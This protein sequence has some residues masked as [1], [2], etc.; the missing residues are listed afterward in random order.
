[1]ISN[2]PAAEQGDDYPGKHQTDQFDQDCRHHFAP[3]LSHHHHAT[4][5]PPLLALLAAEGGV[6]LVACVDDDP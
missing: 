5:T 4:P 6:P 3:L 1:M 2:L